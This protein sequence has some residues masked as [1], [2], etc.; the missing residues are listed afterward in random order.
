MCHTLGSC[1]R[2]ECVLEWVC[3]CLGQWCEL[4][5]NRSCHDP[6]EH[7][8]NDHPSHPT[9]RL[10]QSC[11]PA[12]FYGLQHLFW[13]SPLMPLLFSPGQRHLHRLCTVQGR[14]GVFAPGQDEDLE[15]RRFEAPNRRRFDGKSSS[16]PPQ[17]ISLNVLGVPVTRSTLHSLH[18][19]R[20][21][22]SC[23]S[24]FCMSLTCKLHGCC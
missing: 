18:Q 12:E 3:G 11:H 21:R 8:P 20:H 13:R 6:P 7:V 9:V 22:L 14:G 19:K 15:R 16:E 1:A 17:R 2:G 24:E 4:L 5:R 23:S 10:R